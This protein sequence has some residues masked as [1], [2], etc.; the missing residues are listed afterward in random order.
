MY[1][2]Y[3]LFTNFLLFGIAT[4][5]CSPFIPFN[6]QRVYKNPTSLI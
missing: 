3:F 4:S 1:L 5:H 6:K 2:M